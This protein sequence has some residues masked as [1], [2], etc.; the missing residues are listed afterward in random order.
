M[1]SASQQSHPS[2]GTH[3]LRGRHFD[4]LS[5]LLDAVPVFQSDHAR[6][7]C[8]ADPVGDGHGPAWF[9][10]FGRRNYANHPESVV[11]V[12]ADES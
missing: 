8:M 2:R 12:R 9:V 11:S 4:R 6:L 7:L 5:R 1:G 10:Q 3:V